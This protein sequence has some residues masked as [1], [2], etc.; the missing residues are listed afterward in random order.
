[1]V[2]SVNDKTLKRLRVSQPAEPVEKLMLQLL[3]SNE[4]DHTNTELNQFHKITVIFEFQRKSLF[5]IFISN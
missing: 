2:G 5:P 3:K 4:I 1:M